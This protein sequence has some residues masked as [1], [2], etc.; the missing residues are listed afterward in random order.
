[1]RG[2]YNTVAPA[3]TNF[4]LDDTWKPS[5]QLERQRRHP[6]RRLPLRPDRY[7][8]SRPVRNRKPFRRSARSCGRTA[9]TCST[10][11]QHGAVISRLDAE[12]HAGCVPVRLHAG[13]RLGHEPGQRTTTTSGSRASARRTPFEPA[14]RS[15]ARSWGEYAQP[16]SSAFQQYNNA[17]YNLPNVSPNTLVLSAGVL[18]PDP[19]SVPRRVVQPRPLVGTPGEELRRVLEVDAVPA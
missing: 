18:Q 12:Q 17:A 6:L 5:E 10:A 15:S 1:M 11:S 16:A 14:R 8:G 13:E 3:F 9:T 7:Y 2:A 4:E 19:P